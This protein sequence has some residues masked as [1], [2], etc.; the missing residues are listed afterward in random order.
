MDYQ[1]GQIVYSKSGHD[2]GDAL[3]VLSVDEDWVWLA[4]GRRRKLEKPKRKKRIHIQPTSYV[5]KETAE[6]LRRKEYI[7]DAEIA[8]ALKKYQKKQAVD[9]EGGSGPC[10]KTT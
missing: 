2:K 3:M 1:I 7:L 9:D 5:E 4:D 8:K 6:K 10:Q